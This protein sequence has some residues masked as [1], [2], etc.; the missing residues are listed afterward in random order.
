MVVVPSVN[1]RQ[2]NAR[3]LE[4]LLDATVTLARQ[5][6]AD[7]DEPTEAASRDPAQLQARL[8]LSLMADGLPTDEV[9]NRLR[10]V[11]RA[12]PSSSSW[13]FVNQ[14]FGGREPLATATE[15]LAAVSN[16]SMYTFKAAGAQILVEREVLRH[17]AARASLGDAEGCFTPGGSIA[18]LVALLL[19]RNAA[20]P[21][22]RERGLDGSR[23][24]VYTSE[25]AHYSIPKAAGILGIG[26]D[27]VRRVP[28]RP[29]GRMD[30][31]ALAGLLAADR[32]RGLQPLLVN[33][34]AGTTVRGAFDP[35][36]AI[37]AVA[38]EYGA[39]LHVDGALGGSFVLCESGRDLVDGIELADS[40]AWN[41]HKMMAVPLQC[42]VLLVSRRG[43]LARSLD[44]T[45]D[46]LFQAHETIS[47]PAIGR[48]NA[49]V[50]TTRSS[51]GWPGSGWATEAGTS[52][53]AV[54]S[55]SPSERLC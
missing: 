53:S 29:D 35:I 14:L 37:A 47:I 49:G 33:A 23:R 22:A 24:I 9:L 25:E 8:D 16:V 30:V 43:E 13:R 1:R 54:S 21:A 27:N 40:F 46:Y 18:N 11:Q 26:R 7:E 19:A 48:S 20:A 17:M 28:A 36:R 12:T 44:E 32:A 15:L 41:P 42:S 3:E 10:E 38:R 31:D 4:R 50:A 6:V 45:A 5:L 39:W 55:T 2:E 52:E 34:T 51:C